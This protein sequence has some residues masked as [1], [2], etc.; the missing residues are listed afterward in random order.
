[1]NTKLLQRVLVSPV[2]RRSLHL[3]SG[4]EG[5][6]LETD[7]ELKESFQIVLGIP[8]LIQPGLVADWD[9]NVLEVILGEKTTSVVSD[10]IRQHGKSEAVNNVVAAWIRD[11][12]GKKGVR[13]SISQYSQR[14]P[15][16]RL[17]WRQMP[18]DPNGQ[19]AA[20]IR[21]GELQ[22]ACECASRDNGMKHI[23]LAQQTAQTWGYHIPC[24]Q[25]LI[26]AVSARTALELGCGAGVGTYWILE[27]IT[28][29]TDL[30]SIDIDI[31]C[32]ANCLGIREAMDR[33][34]KL[35]PVVASFWNLP[36]ADASMDLVCSHYGIDETREVTAALREISRVLRPGGSM[37]SVSRTD[38]TLRL[39]TYLDGL[40]LSD[41]E[42]T[43]MAEEVDLYSGPDHFAA[44]ANACGLQ[45]QS[46]ERMRGQSSH[47]RTIFEFRKV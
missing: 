45:M 46:I 31:V 4:H 14:R 47:D 44:R 22:R 23:A 24:F 13:E 28:R 40:G 41:A 10:A 36:F 16:D 37:I 26:A 3:A 15:S 19:L 6:H 11:N 21:D 12:M 33:V 17:L 29:E 25:R 32:A 35:H 43:G 8:V 27:S 1:M 5:I 30:L 42:L 20:P 9:H 7:S 34:D 2:S 18:V 39:K 38:P